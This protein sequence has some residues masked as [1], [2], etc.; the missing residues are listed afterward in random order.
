MLCDNALVDQQA[1][2][3]TNMTLT[4]VQQVV[5]DAKMKEGYIVIGLF[6]NL[7]GLAGVDVGLVK[8]KHRI[9]INCLGYDSYVSG[10]VYQE[11]K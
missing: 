8:G 10:L 5:V 2:E 7:S 9:H 1:L 6:H 4:Q 11:I 3:D